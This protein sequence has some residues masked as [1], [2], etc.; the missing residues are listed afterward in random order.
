M[1]ECQFSFISFCL[2]DDFWKHKK[3]FVSVQGSAAGKKYKF[4]VTGHGKYEKIPV[5]EDGEE[6]ADGEDG[7]TQTLVKTSLYEK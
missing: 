4:V 7:E 3:L 5:D 1:I 6:F 2:Y